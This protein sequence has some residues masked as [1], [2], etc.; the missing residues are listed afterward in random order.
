M[1]GVPEPGACLMKT[2]V[3]RRRDCILGGFLEETNK[4]FEAVLSGKISEFS[5]RK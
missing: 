4:R 2:R 5:K 1:D 3:C